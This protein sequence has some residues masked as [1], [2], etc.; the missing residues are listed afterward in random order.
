MLVG[1]LPSIFHANKKKKKKK[2]LR[3][4]CLCEWRFMRP[5][6]FYKYYMEAKRKEKTR[7]TNDAA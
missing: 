1:L 5:M 6:Y 4:P 2:A 7:K 3:S